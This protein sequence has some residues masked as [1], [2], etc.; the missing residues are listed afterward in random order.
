MKPSFLLQVGLVV[1]L[2]KAEGATRFVDVD[3]AGGGNG[4]S[5]EQAYSTLSE[6]LAAAQ[7]GDEVWVAGGTYRPTA[8]ND[9]TK[10]FELADGVSLYGGFAGNESV[11]E[12]RD[13]A[14]NLTIL[15]GEIGDPEM[16]SDNS[17]HVVR[18]SGFGTTCHLDGFTV[19]GG[20]AD[21]PTDEDLEGGGILANSATLALRECV[22][23][24]C[25][26]AER[27]GGVR[28]LE[29]TASLERCRVSGNS[30]GRDGGGISSS[31][32]DLTVVDCRL[33]ENSA[34]WDA[35]GAHFAGGTSR[36]ERCRF[37]GNQAGADA[38]AIYNE[39][40][41]STYLGC[42]ISGNHAG[43]DGGAMVLYYSQP[44]LTGLTISGNRAG[45]EG[46]AIFNIFSKG[47]FT[48]CILWENSARGGSTTSPSSSFY[49]FN[50]SH[51][52]PFSHCIV[53]NS[54]G[55]GNWDSA[56]GSDR[57][58]NLDIDPRFLSPILPVEAPDTGGDL[59][60]M[61]DSPAIGAGD[62]SVASAALDLDGF[63][64]IDDN[65]G[66]DIGA[67]EF[68]THRLIPH[69]E[70]PTHHVLLARAGLI[71]EAILDL[72][73]TYGTEL[74]SSSILTISPGAAFTAEVS[75]RGR[76]SLEPTGSIGSGWITLRTTKGSAIHDLLL[77]VET[78]SPVI[79][80]DPTAVGSEDGSSWSDAA[81][82]LHQIL[83]E[84]E[85]TTTGP[86]R[87]IWVRGGS[88]FPDES[89]E[90]GSPFAL[91]DGLAVYGGFAG[92]ETR[93]EDR[94]PD[95]HPTI[96][97]RNSDPSLRAPS[98]P[99]VSATAVGERAILDGFVLPGE[100]PPSGTFADYRASA[101]VCNDASPIIASCRFVDG[102]SYI[103]GGA[104]TC[105]NRSS[106]HFISCHFENN[107]ADFDGGGVE[108]IESSPKFTNC[109]FGGNIARNI[110]GA[111]FSS[112]SSPLFE[113][114]IFVGNGSTSGT[115]RGGAV[116][117]SNSSPVFVR[118]EFLGNRAGDDGGAMFNNGS[119]ISISDCRFSENRADKGGAIAN[120]S[121]DLSVADTIFED[122]FA[123]ED[124]GAIHHD[125]SDGTVRDSMFTGNHSRQSGGAIACLWS[126][127][128]LESCSFKGNFA[129]DS[130]G[131]IHHS[132][133][134]GSMLHLEF[135]ENRAAGPGGAI[136][137]TFGTSSPGIEGC[138][139]AWNLASTTGG[140]VKADYGASPSFTNCTLSGNSADLG[141]GALQLDNAHP[142]CRNTIIWDNSANGSFNTPA[143]SVENVNGATPT[144]AHCLI[145]GS[146]SS[147]AWNPAIGIDSGDNHDEM[148]GF[149]VPVHPTLDPQQGAD[150]RLRN[151]SI[152]I[153][154]GELT[155]PSTATDLAGQPRIQGSTIDLGP[156][157]GGHDVSFSVLFPELT[158]DGDDNRNGLDNFLEYALGGNPAAPPIDCL[159]PELRE[160]IFSSGLRFGA[161][162][163]TVEIR[164][165]YDLREWN[166]LEPADLLPG[167]S[168]G[169]SGPREVRSLRIDS[170]RNP[171]MFLRQEFVPQD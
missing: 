169:R 112:I 81:T 46:G 54:G 22:I 142:V 72:P 134:G 153:D 9:R 128:E 106:P 121:S 122:N 140:A 100:P 87:E 104:V 102:Y 98:R 99:I 155:E 84:S 147:V 14:K 19:T 73:E 31:L 20:Q 56:F 1:M 161:T 7:P 146:G 151:G 143:S 88:H 167:E 58:N 171:R 79:R 158:K 71:Y 168:I 55:S 170:A 57:G 166:E 27:G 135:R 67:Y 95:D 51:F 125:Q 92:S 12:Q 61:S 144:F 40:T 110:G 115:Y 159:T 105:S 65:D 44:I 138:L 24:S 156:L 114:C 74:D 77:T 15:S 113:D 160:S 108:I 32:S 111:V 28:F 157:E 70:T 82:S 165:S 154:A 80:V 25:Y 38:G 41:S 78:I 39:S 133:S 127:S 5:W 66:I 139:F 126:T 60:L 50:G 97:S 23:E 150:F 52:T 75:S 64:R 148:P 3:V 16:V 43:S 163:F 118:C 47:T 129:E 93:R 136:H 36:L 164:K 162:D 116:Y 96:L 149:L 33:I 119:P 4:S 6:A 107:R 30:S 68:G 137:L 131:A 8:D 48:N 145:A 83:E 11:R 130:G 42:L 53:A 94:N 85:G 26:A 45:S 49:N 117:N 62:E 141:G 86:P 37:L 132:S 59:H 34:V 13:T 76:V 90:S 10:S 29:T 123:Y 21:G 63:P 103:M 18:A 101:L 35:G 124:G 17:Y 120:L 89:V 2:T 109:H 69:E 91:S 152:A